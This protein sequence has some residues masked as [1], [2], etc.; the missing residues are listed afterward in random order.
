MNTDTATQPE[1]LDRV[2]EDR[3]ALVDY[4]QTLAPWL[5]RTDASPCEG[6]SRA[7]HQRL[8]C[9][10]PDKY[11]W[12]RNYLDGHVTGLSPYIRHGVLSLSQVKEAALRKVTHPKKV[13]KF[14]Q[15]L[16]WRDFWQRIYRKHPS[17]IWHDIED[18]KTG[19]RAAE[20]ATILPNDIRQAQ[21]GVACIDHFIKEL[22]E[23]GYLHNH[24]RMYLASY[25]VHWRKIRW[26]AGAHWFLHHLLDGDPASNNLSWQWVAS[27]FSHKP[28]IFNL[29]NVKK[30]STVDIDTRPSTNVV[31]DASYPEL[32]ERLF[33]NG[34]GS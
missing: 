24:A 26:Q 6:G 7:A 18:Y 8:G 32:T 25:I 5:E 21:T 34:V 22:V 19:W 12:T 9:I 33:P 16:A 31:L 27:T 20:Y 3:D 30:Y 10:V 28:Y 11:G 13:E 23:T 1:R 15:E 29:E 2:F 4:V 17:W 14:I